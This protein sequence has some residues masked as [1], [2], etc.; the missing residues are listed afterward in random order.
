MQL[1]KIKIFRKRIARDLEKVV[2]EW[3]K[4]MERVITLKEI[5]YSTVYTHPIEYLSVCIHYRMQEGIPVSKKDDF[6]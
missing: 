3:L 2:N 4:E 6:A 5:K 1:D